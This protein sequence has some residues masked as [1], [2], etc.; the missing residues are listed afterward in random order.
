MCWI[1]VQDLY[2]VVH[3]QEAVRGAAG[4]RA[5]VDLL[6]LDAVSRRVT[7]STA[8]PQDLSALQDTQM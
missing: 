6:N 5:G 2:P 7:H 1:W 8:T 4:I 3:V